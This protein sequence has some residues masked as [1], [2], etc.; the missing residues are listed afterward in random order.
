[1]SA[2]WGPVP[3]NADYLLGRQAAL[4]CEMRHT[5]AKL[6]GDAATVGDP[7]AWIQISPWGTLGTVAASAFVVATLIVP[8]RTHADKAKQ[9]A[10]STDSSAPKKSS[11]VWGAISA[12]FFGLVRIV[13]KEMLNAAT[14]GD[15]PGD[16]PRPSDTSKVDAEFESAL[17]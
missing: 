6:K 17:L 12:L 4:Q 16:S 9:P 10:R 5:I 14:V 2:L 1:M 13:L 7:H 8:A 3:N 11:A 15:Q